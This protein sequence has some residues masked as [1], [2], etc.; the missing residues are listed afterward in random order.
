MV[1]HSVA[2][3]LGALATLLAPGTETKE[4]TPKPCTEWTGTVSGN[5]PSVSFTGRLCEDKSGHVKGTLTWS[6]NLSGMNV[7]EVAGAWSS[8][9]ASL[10]MHD[11]AIVESK[12]KPGWRFCLVDEYDLNGDRSALNGSYHSEACHDTAHVT[13]S[14]TK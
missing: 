12:P 13:L 1:F 11:V 7:R 9:H 4:T 3:L 6:S 5:D 8:D 10:T 14:A 2:A